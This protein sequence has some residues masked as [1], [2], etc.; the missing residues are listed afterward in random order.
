[1]FEVADTMIDGI[2]TAR[3]IVKWIK[4]TGLHREMNARAI[5]IVCLLYLCLPGCRKETT[6]KP[7]SRSI[8]PQFQSYELP[9]YAIQEKDV[10]YG[11][12]GRWITIRYVLK[13]DASSN[14]TEVRDRIKTAL[15]QDGWLQKPL[16]ARKYVLSKIYE[17]SPNDLYYA[18]GPFKDDPQHW[19]YNQ[20]VHISDEGKV[21]VCYY[22]VGW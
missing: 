21:L 9:K 12:G 4:N 11:L 14:P 13:P 22:E 5:M 17:T 3:K 15:E 16:P 20:A 18:H 7:S 19:F 6:S 1:M 2:K 8:G 10:V